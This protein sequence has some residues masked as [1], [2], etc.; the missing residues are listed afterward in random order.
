MSSLNIAKTLNIGVAFF[1]ISPFKSCYN[2]SM[3]IRDEHILDG[4]EIVNELSMEVDGDIIRE[5]MVEDNWESLALFIQEM[6]LPELDIS[7][8]SFSEEETLQFRNNVL[9]LYSELS[10]GAD[11]PSGHLKVSDILQNLRKVSDCY[12]INY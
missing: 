3:A 1:V 6:M 5:R 7:V 8:F 9:E 4:Y 12:N 11:I 10:G 2:R